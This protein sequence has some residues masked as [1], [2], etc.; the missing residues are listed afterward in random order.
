MIVAVV[1]ELP[2]V[3]FTGDS[4]FDEFCVNGGRGSSLGEAVVADWDTAAVLGDV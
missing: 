1:E 2:D 3:V 4:E